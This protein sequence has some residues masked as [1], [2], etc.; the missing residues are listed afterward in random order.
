MSVENKRSWDKFKKEQNPR[1]RGVEV[2]LAEVRDDA[3][4]FEGHSGG[5]QSQS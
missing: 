3:D 5:E 4:K 2:S 1:G